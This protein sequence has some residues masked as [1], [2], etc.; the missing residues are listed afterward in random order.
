MLPGVNQS[1][2]AAI[3]RESTHK[4]EYLNLRLREKQTKGGTRLAI[5]DRPNFATVH[6][7][8]GNDQGSQ[9]HKNNLMARYCWKTQGDVKQG[10][11]IFISWSSVRQVKQWPC[12]SCPGMLN[13]HP[14]VEQWWKFFLPEDYPPVGCLGCCLPGF[15]PCLRMRSP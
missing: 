8:R 13:L 12:G 4:P 1:P 11:H 9:F 6:T 3:P 7:G 15:P 10:P 2:E 5:P 14:G